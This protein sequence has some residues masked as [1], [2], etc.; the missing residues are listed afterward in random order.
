MEQERTTNLQWGNYCQVTTDYSA[1]RGMFNDEYLCVLN[2]HIKLTVV[3]MADTLQIATDHLH[4]TDL[5]AHY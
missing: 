5:V 3:T 2:I 1:I 4:L